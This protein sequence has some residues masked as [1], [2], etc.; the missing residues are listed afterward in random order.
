MAPEI[1]VGVQKRRA[2]PSPLLFH[3][4]VS[5]L[6]EYGSGLVCAT[7]AGRLF[8]KKQNKNPAVGD[9]SFSRSGGRIPAVA[10]ARRRRGARLR[11]YPGDTGVWPRASSFPQARSGDVRL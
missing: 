7:G 3:T 5:N 8:T 9:I 11:T 4:S 6:E 2:A 10:W 1:Q